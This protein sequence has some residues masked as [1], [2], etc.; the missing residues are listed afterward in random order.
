LVKFVHP[1][2]CFEDEHGD[3][4]DAGLS[5]QST[6]RKKKKKDGLEFY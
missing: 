5:S 6:K 4:E 2:P 3:R 1:R